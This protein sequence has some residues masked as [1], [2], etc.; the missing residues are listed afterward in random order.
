MTDENFK[1]AVN[2]QAFTGRQALKIGLIDEIGDRNSAINY[3]K[4]R[5]IDTS[6][7]IINI[8]LK[9]KRKISIFNKLIN[10]IFFKVNSEN[11]FGS[12]TRSGAIS[13]Y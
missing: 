7:P 1:I 6:L 5:N 11:A 2:G 4:S 13:I 8:P 9:E 3:L 10:S 12:R